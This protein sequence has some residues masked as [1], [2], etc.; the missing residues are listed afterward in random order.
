MVSKPV[1]MPLPWV[2]GRF[3]YV[4][5]A[6]TTVLG[7]K[8][9]IETFQLMMMIFSYDTEIFVMYAVLLVDGRTS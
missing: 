7:V 3:C 9:L 8:A 6:P 5:L 2:L 1:F 4:V